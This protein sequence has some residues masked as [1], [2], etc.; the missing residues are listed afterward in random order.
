M[1]RGSTS[2]PKAISKWNKNWTF[3]WN[4]YMSMMVS[5]AAWRCACFISFFLSFQIPPI[6]SC[7]A[8]V[9]S[10]LLEQLQKCLCTE[11]GIYWWISW[12]NEHRFVFFDLNIIGRDY[13]I[14][15]WKWVNNYLL[16]YLLKYSFSSPLQIVRQGWI[17]N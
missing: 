1:Y 4:T 10:I 13:N 12:Q 6:Y 9:I 7:N 2:S 14:Q 3:E 15:K 11:E 8:E 5:V 17:E 16:R